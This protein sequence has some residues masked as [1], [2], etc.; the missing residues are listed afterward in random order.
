[1][2]LNSMQSLSCG[3]RL[4]TQIALS[5]KSNHNHNHAIYTP[6]ELIQRV[7]TCNTLLRANPLSRSLNLS[8]HCAC[9]M[10]ILNKSLIVRSLNTARANSS[11]KPA[12]KNKKANITLICKMVET[13]IY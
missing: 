8:I 5:M 6:D 7:L 13:R 4:T 2:P 10:Y 1:M 3:R 12:H 11:N 9:P